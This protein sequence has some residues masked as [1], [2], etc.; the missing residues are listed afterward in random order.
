MDP[1]LSSSLTMR[2]AV[3]APIMV[4]P[5]PTSSP[6][7]GSSALANL[8]PMSPSS[9]VSLRHIQVPRTPT[10]LKQQCL[11]MSRLVTLI[12]R[13]VGIKFTQRGFAFHRHSNHRDQVL[14]YLEALGLFLWLADPRISCRPEEERLRLV[15]DLVRPCLDNVLLQEFL[16]EPLSLT[17]LSGAVTISP[18]VCK[19]RYVGFDEEMNPGKMEASGFITREFPHCIFTNSHVMNYWIHLVS[20]TFHFYNIKARHWIDIDRS[21]PEHIRAVIVVRGDSTDLTIPD[22]AVIAFHPD[23]PA[24]GQLDKLRELVE[25][26]PSIFMHVSDPPDVRDSQEK[27]AEDEKINAHLSQ[28]LLPRVG[29]RVCLVHYGGVPSAKEAHLVHNELNE[30]PQI[31]LYGRITHTTET[32]EDREREAL[33]AATHPPRP[34]QLLDGSTFWQS[35]ASDIDLK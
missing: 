6:Q 17:M 24:A 33:H 23:S 10:E 20:S 13:A 34:H 26:F 9:S 2:P 4:D 14:T 31:S 7:L 15:G 35:S 8:D 27:V 3:T 28:F 1:S 29:E 19:I 22:L 11:S 30:L 21:S 16:C 12:K 18:S 25:V 5:L 32:E